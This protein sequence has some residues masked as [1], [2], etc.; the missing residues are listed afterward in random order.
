MGR[1]G[2]AGLH[3]FILVQTIIWSTISIL[4]FVVDST[5]KL[6][7]RFGARPWSRVLLWASRVKV[8][9]EGLANLERPVKGPMVLVCNHQSL[10]DILALLA[11]LPVDFKFVVKKELGK[12]PLW[13]YAMKKAGYIFVDRGQSNQAG[14]LMREAVEK[15]KKG[16]AVLF[17]AEG[18]RS[19]DGRL[20]EFKRGAFVLASLARADVAPVAISGSAQVLPKK[21]WAIRP[22][23]IKISVLPVICDPALKKNSRLLMEATH[24]ALSLALEAPLA[25][26]QEA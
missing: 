22:G 14:E 4:L 13:G 16:S 2:M 24:R 20:G 5:G 12:V 18:T 17:F 21:S 11:S 7:H 19:D 9:A 23:R 3:L 15:I 26:A 6:T 25:A 8:E 1:V 10:F